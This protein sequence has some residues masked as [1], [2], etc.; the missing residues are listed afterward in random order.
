MARENEAKTYLEDEVLGRIDELAVKRGNSRST[1]I[2]DLL[3]DGLKIARLRD[4]AAECAIRSSMA[5]VDMDSEGRLS[6]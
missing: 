4:E 5:L 2:R 3:L 6:A 1:T